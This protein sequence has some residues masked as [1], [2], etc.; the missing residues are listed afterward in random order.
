MGSKEQTRDMS[1]MGHVELG[2][3]SALVPHKICVQERPR[4]MQSVMR[5]KDSVA[6]W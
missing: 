2:E 3:G 1:R 6:S 5:I 4:M